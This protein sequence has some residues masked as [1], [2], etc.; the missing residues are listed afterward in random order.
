MERRR[1]NQQRRDDE[2]QGSATN[3]AEPAVQR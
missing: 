1:N 3:K 2:G